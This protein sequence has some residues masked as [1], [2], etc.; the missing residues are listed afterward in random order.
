[1]ELEDADEILS[2]LPDMSAAEVDSLLAK[3]LAEGEKT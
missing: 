2:R 1:V 3:V